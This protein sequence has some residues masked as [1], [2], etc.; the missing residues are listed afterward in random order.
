[1]SKQSS[2][3]T[4]DF[5]EDEDDDDAFGLGDQLAYLTNIGKGY[6][7]DMDQSGQNA[8]ILKQ[9]SVHNPSQIALWRQQLQ[10]GSKL[11]CLDEGCLWWTAV[12][13]DSDGYRIKIRYDGFDARWDEWIDRGSTRIAPYK[14]KAKGG[15]ESKGVSVHLKVVGKKKDKRTGRTRKIYKQGFLVKQGKR[16]KSYKTR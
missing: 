4:S 10:T 8:Q 16:F 3:L 2:I 6:D 11:D 12:V 14:T 13:T 15:R 5:N 9:Q 1:M 7:D